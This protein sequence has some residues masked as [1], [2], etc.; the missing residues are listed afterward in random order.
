VEYKLNKTDAVLPEFPEEPGCYVFKAAGRP[1]YVGKAK[2]LSKRLKTYFTT[3]RAGDPKTEA[4]LARADAVEFII[5]ANETEALILEMNLIAR[6][7]PKYNVSVHGFPYIKVTKE[8]FPRIYVTREAHDWETGRYVGPFTDAAAVRRTVELTNRA[9]GLRM[10][11][12]DL[13]VKPPSRPCLD[14][15]M[16]ICVG[17]CADA[18]SQEDYG[19]LAE[20][21]VKFIIGRRAGVLSELEGRMRAAS[22]VFE[23]EEA[24]KWRDV[25]R[26]L[27]RAVADQYAL[28]NRNISADAVACAVRGDELY[29]V[30]L[31]VRE[32][33]MVDRVTLR[34]AAPAGN[35]LEELLL[36]HYGGGA[37]IP[38]RIVLTRSFP[39]RAALAES[40]AEKRDGAVSVV[41]PKWGELAHL[42]SVARK[43]LDYFVETAELK[44]AR[45]GELA[46]IFEE[47][48]AT[49]GAPAP[50]AAIEM[51]DISTAGPGTVVGSLV[52]FVEGVP[53]KARYR[54]YRV[55]GA[56]A[57]DDLAAIAEVTK[58]RLRRA[59]PGRPDVLLVD[60]GSSQL[61][62]SRK[63]AKDAGAAGQI[64]AAF[65]KDPDRLFVADG[66]MPAPLSEAAL[67][68]LAR[69]RDEAH[70]FAVEYLRKV[71]G[72][73]VT[74]SILDEVRGIGP[75]RKRAL[76]KYFGSVE[77]VFAAPL[78]KLAAAPKMD[79]RAASSLFDYL[80]GGREVRRE[81]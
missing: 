23:Y 33:R 71:R 41:V 4:M 3:G 21:A 19:A 34:A 68:F 50:P 72:R 39:G 15:E 58:R 74:K 36:G 55:N 53:D 10:C 17:P 42:A 45:R 14:F 61:A 2:V 30:I 12:Y 16:G 5:T 38:R 47:I 65:A 51:I 69:V 73:A 76:L 44:K 32:G 18:L 6:L 11:R 37:D 8:R 79:A 22:A 64:M 7:Q 13:D 24:A 57:G 54:R 31:R 28:V 20:K 27:S 78:E 49:L 35:H 26:G 66:K 81:K 80:H 77:K 52:A 9:F 70:R 60:G 25:I 56:K 75:V 1:I 48:G 59:G 40:L 29:G 46:G 63:A 62:A 43:N 67:L